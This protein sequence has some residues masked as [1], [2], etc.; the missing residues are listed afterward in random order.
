MSDAQD[1]DRNETSVPHAGASTDASTEPNPSKR[2][3]E[4]GGPGAD[5]P[6]GSAPASRGTK[7]LRRSRHDRV[8]TGLCGGLGTFFGVDPV[9]FRVA[10]VLLAFAGGGGVILYLVMALVVPAEGED[11]AGTRTTIRRGAEDLADSFRG[12]TDG[13]RDGEAERNRNLAALVLILLG[14][15]FLFRNVGW[16]DWFDAGW[17]WPV[18]LI[19]L[20]VWLLA[21]RR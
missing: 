18:I 13:L 8:F 6:A 1:H 4:A 7:H 11:D 20:G 2:K 15:F 17:V 19:V 21:R 5:R 12:V 14:I 9:W 3:A 10:F 16:L